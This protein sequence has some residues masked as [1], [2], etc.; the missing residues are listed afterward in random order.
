M[1]KEGLTLSQLIENAKKVL[2]RDHFED[3]KPKVLKYFSQPG[4]KVFRVNGIVKGEVEEYDLNINFEQVS[5]SDTQDR[6]H[7]LRVPT[8]GRSEQVFMEQL[9]Y[10]KHYV[11]VWCSCTWFRF[12]CEWYLHEH[13]ALFPR[14]QPRPYTKVA[15]S[16][17]PSV[18]PDQLPCVCKHIAQLAMYLKNTA[19]VK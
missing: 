10:D 12:A 16:T 13:N 18:N 14:R 9:T 3:R 1:P 2:G 19:I 6:K 17:R 15:G 5:F 8:A 7:F 4:V 11:K